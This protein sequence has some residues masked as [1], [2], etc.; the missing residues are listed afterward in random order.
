MA[1]AS[2]YEAESG[3]ER[4]SLQRALQSARTAAESA[5]RTAAE[6]AREVEQLR[7]E[8]ARMTEALEEVTSTASGAGASAN[9]RESRSLHRR[10]LRAH[11]GG[12]GAAGTHADALLL[13]AVREGDARALEALLNGATSP[14][15][16]L[17]SPPPP[18]TRSWVHAARLGVPAR[19][20]KRRG[21]L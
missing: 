20:T 8:L 5:E 9:V 10:L 2:E 12:H 3:R 6:R 21:Y 19:R 1:I 16:V 7:A 4:E 17:D 14:V 18:E 15:D 11:L 13:T